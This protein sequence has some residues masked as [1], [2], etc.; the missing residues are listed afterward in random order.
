MAFHVIEQIL[1]KVSLMKRVM[2]F[3]KGNLSPRYIGSFKVLESVGTVAYRLALTPN[4]FGVHQVFCVSMMKRYYG[5]GEYIIKWDLILLDKDLQHKNESV[6]ILDR[7]VQKL[8]IKE[9]RST[10]IQRKY[11][12]VEEATWITKKDIWDNY[13][14]LFEDSGLRCS[15]PEERFGFILRWEKSG[16]MR[17]FGHNTLVVLKDDYS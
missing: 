4:L 17:I 12:P 6:G 1:L 3:G 9:I 14:H 15:G 11:H 7:D 10:Q 8:R 2:R 13:P 16:L 5:N